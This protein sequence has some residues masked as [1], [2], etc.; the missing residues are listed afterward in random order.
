M[1]AAIFHG[2]GK[3]MT[4]EE[5]PDP[6][7]RPGEAVIKVCRCGICGSDI[8]MTSGNYADYPA[9]T[10]LGHEYAGEVVAVGKD[11]STLKIGQRVSAMPAKGC[12]RCSACL[13]GFPLGCAAMVGM[14]GGYGEYMRIAV[15]A[16]IALPDT[17]SMADGALVEPLAVG[18]RGVA[19][20]GLEPGAKVAVLGA[21]AIGLAAIYWAR[22][23][24]AGR[25]IAMSRSARRADLATEMGAAGFEAFGDGEGDRLSAALGDMPDVV[26]E[27]AGAVGMMQKAVELV[28]P[29]GTIVSLGFCGS[30]DPIIPSLATWKQ[31]T[32]KFSFAYDLREFQHCADALDAGHVEPRMMVSDTISLD[33]LP[34]VFE[35]LRTGSNQTKVHVDPWAAV[36][37]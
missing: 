4:I 33:A 27:C 31:V 16:A 25:I 2:A 12:G 20:A 21:G 37:A 3:P 15:P 29:G 11:V 13:A 28:R 34:E 19:L 26:L 23:L 18:L 8:S 35:A 10:T 17:L 24:G 5:V 1:R 14:V 36:A 9:G 32:M 22:L 7:P 6:E 30:P